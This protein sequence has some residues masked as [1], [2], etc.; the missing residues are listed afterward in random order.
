MDPNTFREGT[1]PATHTP[2]APSEGTWEQTMLYKTNESATTNGQQQ[3]YIKKQLKP[4]KT[5]INKCKDLHAHEKNPN[6]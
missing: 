3:D 6:K 2:R 5:Y 1:S 4:S